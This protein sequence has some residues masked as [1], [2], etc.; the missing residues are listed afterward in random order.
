MKP[1]CH[2]D[3][4]PGCHLCLLFDT[5][6]AYRQLWG[7]GPLPASPPPAAVTRSLPCLYLGEV[8]DKL[9]CPCPGKWVRKCGIHGACTITGC[10]S[11]PD[12]EEAG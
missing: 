7:G 3:S 1:C 5:N 8:V 9:G 10:K 2:A 4:E 11:C 6:P 12:Y